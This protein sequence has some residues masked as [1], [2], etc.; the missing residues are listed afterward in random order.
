MALYNFTDTNERAYR[1]DLPSEA[2]NFNGVFL[3]HEID[4]YRTLNVMGRERSGV[5]D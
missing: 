2:L 4:G 1:A 3:E 5:R